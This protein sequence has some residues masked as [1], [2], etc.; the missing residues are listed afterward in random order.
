MVGV[1]HP[2]SAAINQHGASLERDVVAKSG[3]RPCGPAL[4][5]KYR[6]RVKPVPNP[7]TKAHV[8]EIGHAIAFVTTAR[9]LLRSCLV[10]AEIWSRSHIAS[11]VHA[12]RSRARCNVPRQDGLNT[13]VMRTSRRSGSETLKS[14]VTSPLAMNVR[15]QKPDIL[16]HVQ[17]ETRK[18]HPQHGLHLP[19][20]HDGADG[21]S[22]AMN[23]SRM[24][25]MAVQ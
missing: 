10:M 15:D 18:P 25:L 6:C 20:R 16:D 21:L 22:P 2:S 7:P 12:P 13:A 8:D 14:S 1:G 9:L 24:I 19:C 11:G 5:A 4:V 3:R 17:P 23:H